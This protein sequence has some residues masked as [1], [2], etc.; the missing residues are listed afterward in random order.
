MLDG[1]PFQATLDPDGQGGHWLKVDKALREVANVAAGDT[2][3][4]A[5]T[6][7][8]VEPEPRVPADLRRALAANSAASAT[9]ARH[10]ASGAPRLDPLDHLRQEGGNARAAYPGSL[11]HARC[12]QTSR[13]LFRSLGYLQQGVQR[14]GSGRIAKAGQRE[15]MP[16]SRARRFVSANRRGSAPSLG[17]WEPQIRAARQVRAWATVRVDARGEPG[18]AEVRRSKVGTTPFSWPN[19]WPDA[20]V[21]ELPPPDRSGS[22]KPVAG[23]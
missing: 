5:I 8:D 13:L 21:R 11:R 19:R 12:R 23:R 3:T 4:L 7:V 16:A 15:T 9:W 14:A 20:K 17:F 18:K 1:H 10:H 22:R 6:P 2:V